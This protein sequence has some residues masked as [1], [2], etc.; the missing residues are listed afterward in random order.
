MLSIGEGKTG[1]DKHIF[2]RVFLHVDVI[3]YT[4]SALGV[5][6]LALFKETNEV[7]GYNFRQNSSWFNSKLMT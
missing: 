4:I 5:W 3:N 6:L 7:I 2:G 1:F